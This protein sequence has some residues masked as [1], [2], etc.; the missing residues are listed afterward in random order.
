MRKIIF[1]IN[2]LLI[3]TSSSNSQ[4]GWVW[5]NPLPQGNTLNSVFFVDTLNGFAG[6]NCGTLLRTTNGGLNWSF[7]SLEGNPDIISIYFVNPNTGY[8]VGGGL[9]L[10]TTNTGLSWFIASNISSILYNIYFIN[11]N[12]GFVCGGLPNLMQV[13]KTT[14]AG[15][16]W[17][18]N[19]SNNGSYLSSIFF[20]DENSGFSVGNNVLLKTTNSGVNWLQQSFP[21]A[22]L[23]RDIHFINTNTGFVTTSSSGRIL[24]TTN[25]GLNWVSKYQL[26][27]GTLYDVCFVDQNTGYCCGDGPYIVKTTNSGDNWIAMINGYGGRAIY[28]INNQVGFCVGSSGS[29]LKT[30]NGNFWTNQ[31]SGFNYH[32]Y[33]IAF[34]GSYGIAVGGNSYDPAILRTVN[35]GNNWAIV[36][37]GNSGYEYYSSFM[38]NSLTGF[39]VGRTSA[40]N[41]ATLRTTNSGLNWS[42]YSSGVNGRLNSVFFPNQTTGFAVGYYGKIHKTTN[43]GDSW[44]ILSS[45][46]SYEDIYFVNAETGYAADLNGKIGKT[47][48]GGV[49]WVNLLT[50]SS[51]A[52]RSVFFQNVSTGFAVGSNG[53]II[54]TTNEGVDW[55]TLVSNTNVVL[56]SIYFAQQNVGLIVG[57]DGMILRTTDGVNWQRISGALCNNAVDFYSVKFINSF[58]GYISG[59]WGAILMTTN[60]GVTFIQPTSTEIP[61]SFSLFQNYPNPFNPSTKIRFEIPLLRGVSEGQLV[62]HWREGV[63]SSIIIYNSLGQKIATLVNQQLSPGT[64]E[65]EWNAANYPSG[66]YFYKLTSGDYSETKKMILVK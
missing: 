4:S 44:I 12:T 11:D 19:F 1:V 54:K 25:G 16:T 55:V 40:G 47:I 18:L 29:I 60:G 51:I 24:K 42:T 48:D 7:I 8:A 28:F 35:G 39:I 46:S 63:L 13:F 32:F 58:T 43:S 34:N 2:V 10:K 9:I 6:G 64:Y 57:N 31:Y 27:T 20:I 22:Y 26:K 59:E 5:Q 15:T 21:E 14:D 23:P 37:A 17:I 66:L 62:T 56:N 33:D 61:K 49:S 45:S 41:D 3:F 36:G 53:R 65:V 38:L 52:L 50:G 30:T